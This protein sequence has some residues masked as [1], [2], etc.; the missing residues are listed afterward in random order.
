MSGSSR[1]SRGRVWI[2]PPRRSRGAGPRWLRSRGK[3]LGVARLGKG[4]LAALAGRVR[5][6]HPEGV[7]AHFQFMLVMFCCS[8]S[9]TSP[10]QSSSRPVVRGHSRLRAS[11]ISSIT[12]ASSAKSAISAFSCRHRTTRQPNAGI[13][14]FIS[15]TAGARGTT[16]LRA[17]EAATIPGINTAE[18]T[19]RASSARTTS[20]SSDGTGTIHAFQARII[21]ARTTSAPLKP[22][23]SSLSIFR[24]WS[25]TSTR[26]SAR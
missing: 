8:S 15:F 1:R 2:P 18:T 23:G 7:A 17:V 25:D 16:S 4:R 5:S 20:S 13:R 3:G 19:S 6:A 10:C 21:L 12:A 14:S 22:I 11:R 24:S 26:I 9:A